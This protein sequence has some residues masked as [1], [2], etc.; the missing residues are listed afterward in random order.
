MVLE[1]S[2]LTYGLEKSFFQTALENQLVITKKNNE[3]NQKL[4]E[5]VFGAGVSSIKMR[6]WFQNP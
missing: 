6:R 3:P 2:K 1:V 4:T 5:I